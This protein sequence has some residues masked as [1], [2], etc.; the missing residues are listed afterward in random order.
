MML[1]IISIAIVI[2]GIIAHL[3][4]NNGANRKLGYDTAF[5]VSFFFSPI[6]GLLLVLSSKELTHEEIELI[7]IQK[8]EKK[9]KKSTVNNILFYGTLILIFSLIAVLMLNQ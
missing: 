3:V 7:K 5:L 2:N 8:E 4:G 1:T 9:K 6:I